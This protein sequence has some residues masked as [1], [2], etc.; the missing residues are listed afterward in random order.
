MKSPDRKKIIEDLAYIKSIIRDSDSDIAENGVIYVL[1]GLL[2]SLGQILTYAFLYMRD[3]GR[4]SS[5]MPG[6]IATWAVLFCAGWIYSILR[7]RKERRSEGAVLFAKK[8]LSMVW[9]STG[10]SVTIFLFI[11]LI[12]PTIDSNLIHPV[13]SLFLGSAYFITSAVYSKNAMK[14]LSFGWWAGAAVMFI[15][16]GYTNFLIFGAMT[17]LLLVVPGILFYRRSRA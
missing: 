16:P 8:I 17:L 4:I 13:I 15:I 5:V 11:A 2:V 12:I 3:A 7:H 6:I 1:W 9:L 14:Y 10:I